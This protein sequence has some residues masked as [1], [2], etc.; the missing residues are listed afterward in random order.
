MFC[1][2]ASLSVKGSR[3]ILLRFFL[4][5]DF[6]NTVEAS[7]VDGFKNNFVAFYLQ[8]EGAWKNGSLSWMRYRLRL[9]VQYF[10]SQFFIF[11]KLFCHAKTTQVSKWI[12]I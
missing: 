4:F 6:L 5:K 2:G 8:L 10:L 1:K 12:V 9:F 3:K 11:S 7:N